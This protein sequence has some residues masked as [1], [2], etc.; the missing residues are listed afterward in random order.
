MSM[1]KILLLL[2]VITLSSCSAY[3]IDMDEAI[4]CAE[5]YLE[6][7]KESDFESAAGFY[8]NM[9]DDTEPPAR[10]LEKMQRLEEVMGKLI[11]YELSDSSIV[12]RGA[13]LPKAQLEY[14]AR[15]Q[16]TKASYRFTIMKDAGKYKIFNQWVETPN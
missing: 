9:F 8:T 5:G 7:I 14:E 2:A 16:H 3:K 6:A 12:R 13:E 1:Y 10:R 4:A 15:H 11:S